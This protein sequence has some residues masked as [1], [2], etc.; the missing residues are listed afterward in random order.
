MG[1]RGLGRNIH[2]KWQCD[3]E[4]LQHGALK[5]N[6]WAVSVRV[7]AKHMP[8]PGFEEDIEK[9]FSLLQHPETGER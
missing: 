6:V 2:F 1:D 9:V 3:Q 7:L 4:G 5:R 8:A